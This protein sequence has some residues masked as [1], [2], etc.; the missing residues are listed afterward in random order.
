MEWSVARRMMGGVLAFTQRK[1]N[2]PTNSILWLL[3][4]LVPFIKTVLT[5]S[6]EC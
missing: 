6:E 2:I 4:N 5:C 1:D 3:M